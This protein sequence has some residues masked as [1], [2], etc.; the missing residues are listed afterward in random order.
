LLLQDVRRLS[1]TRYY[2][3]ETAKLIIKLFSAVE[4]GYRS[5]P[6]LVSTNVSINLYY[7]FV[8]RCVCVHNII[9]THCVNTDAKCGRGRGRGRRTRTRTR[10]MLQVFRVML[11]VCTFVYCRLN[12]RNVHVQ[13]ITRLKTYTCFI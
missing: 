3:V 11:L 7:V 8:T 4:S 1:V 10:V 6:R 9:T 13:K 12:Y 2:C 5:H